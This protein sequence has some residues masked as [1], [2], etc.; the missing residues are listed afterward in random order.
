MGILAGLGSLLAEEA[1]PQ[2][3]HAAYDEMAKTLPPGTLADGLAQAF[4]SDRTPPFEQMVCGLFRGSDPSQKADLLNQLVRSLGSGRAAEIFSSNGLGRLAA[5]AAAGGAL[6]PAQA[7]EVP[8]QAVEALAKSAAGKDPTIMDRAAGFY[9]QHPTLVK[10]IGVGSLAL[11]MSR[12][13]TAQ[14]V[15]RAAP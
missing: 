12:I 14:K 15:A 6:T 2:E 13:S 3:V 9:A 11:L 10:T 1:P 8:T 5:G 4:H 7:H